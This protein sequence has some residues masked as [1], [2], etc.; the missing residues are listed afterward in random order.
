MPPFRL[1]SLIFVLLLVSTAAAA[2]S[3]LILNVYVDDTA[4]KEALVVGYVNDPQTLS[5]LNAS[6]KLYEDNGQ[7]YAVA[8]SIL[9]AEGDGWRL[10][11][12]VQGYYDEYHAVFYIPGGYEL[13]Q[14]NCSQGL[15]LLSSKYDGSLILDVQGFE[16]QEPEV[17]IRYRA[18]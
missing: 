18:S 6:E 7:F 17:T 13:M 10:E 1:A 16:V 9:T 12:P 11:F 3:R 8:E 5:F 14:I 4:S 2:D 15:E